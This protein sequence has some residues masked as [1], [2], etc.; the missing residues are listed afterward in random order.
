VTFVDYRLI[1]KYFPQAL[2][3]TLITVLL[4][5]LSTS[6]GML[7]GVAGGVMRVSHRKFVRRISLIYTEVM[8]NNP[9]LVKMY[10]L[11]FGLPSLGLYPSAFMCGTIALI[12]HNAAYM[13]DIFHGGITAV[14]Q[15]QYKAARSLGLRPWQTYSYV[16]LPQAFR[17]ALPAL[18]NNWVEILKDTSITSSIAVAELL[19]VTNTLIAGEARPIEFL[20]MAGFIYLALNVLLSGG[21]KF[22]ES[23]YKYV[24]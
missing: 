12:I 11:Y 9:S 24:R 20:G 5:L 8:R 19:Y 3:G 2:E 17:N 14:P 4:F 22:I 7:L 10:F 15:G 23:R 13:M 16:I 18:A 6:G 21:L 1:W